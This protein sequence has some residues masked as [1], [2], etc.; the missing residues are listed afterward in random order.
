MSK[1]AHDVFTLVIIFW[2]FN[3]NPKHVPLGLFEA[4]KTIG[5]ALTKEWI[6]LLDEYGLRSKIIKYVKD[7][8]SNL[9]KRQVLS[10]VKF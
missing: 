3:W 6:N 2:R 10:N 1:G 8:G 4:S 7:E 9:N 5:Q